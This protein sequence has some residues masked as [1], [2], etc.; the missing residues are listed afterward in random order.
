[1]NQRPWNKRTTNACLLAAGICL[2]LGVCIG[3]ASDAQNAPDS[4]SFSANAAKARAD[5]QAAQDAQAREIEA[6]VSVPCQQRL[7]NRKILQLVA[8]RSAAGWQTAQERYGPFFQVIDQRL[9]ALGLKTYTPEQIRQHIAQA[10][11]EAY[12][13]N[14]PDAALAASKRLAADYVVR[15][16]ISTSTAVNPVVQLNEVAVNVD[17]TLSDAAGRVLSEVGTHSESYSGT[18]TLGTAF[19]LVREQADR[20]VAQLYNDYCRKAAGA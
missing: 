1:M 20:M 10:E 11:V 16:S 18:D 15:G 2:C 14:D 6:L 5:E 4:F 17:L 7:K 12:F 19:T 13:N 8:E 3:T 9:R